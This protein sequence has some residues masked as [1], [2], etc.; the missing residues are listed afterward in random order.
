MR[1]LNV[2]SVNKIPKYPGAKKEACFRSESEVGS[3]IVLRI[4]VEQQNSNIR[5]GKHRA[6][7]LGFRRVLPTRMNHLA[8]FL[9]QD[10]Q[11]FILNSGTAVI[12]QV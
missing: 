3:D 8:T 10:E 11:S 2:F 1:D 6:R 12:I 4:L 9:Q 5:L 7:G